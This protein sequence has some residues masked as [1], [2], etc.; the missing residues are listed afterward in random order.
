MIKPKYRYNHK[1]KCWNELFTF[2]TDVVVFTGWTNSD[3][4]FQTKTLPYDSPMIEYYR[5]IVTRIS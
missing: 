2:N 4:S 3:G 5:N 1:S